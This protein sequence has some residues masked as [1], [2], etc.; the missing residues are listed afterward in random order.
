MAPTIPAGET[1]VAVKIV[2]CVFVIPVCVGSAIVY[3][4]RRLLAIVLIG[5]GAS[6]FPEDIETDFLSYFKP[7]PFVEVNGLCIVHTGM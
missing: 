6:F 1:T 7:Q 5:T 3:A 2:G 4:P